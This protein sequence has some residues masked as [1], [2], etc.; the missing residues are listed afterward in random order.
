MRQLKIFI[1]VNFFLFRNSGSLK[2][3]SSC[4]RENG[5][6]VLNFECEPDFNAMTV[7]KIEKNSVMKQPDSQF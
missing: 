7:G 3:I 2:T 1:E 5:C 6:Y 4:K